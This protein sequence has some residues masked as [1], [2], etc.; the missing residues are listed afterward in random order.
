MKR[1]RGA[2]Q[3]LL[4]LGGLLPVAANA[5]MTWHWNATPSA[6]GD[7]ITASMDGCVSSWNSYATYNY[8]IGV[9][10]SS[11]TPT[12][13]AGYL[14]QIRFG[15]SRNYRTAMH[16]SCH[17]LGTG[18]GAGWDG[19]FRN[20]RWTGTY[21]Y[22]LRCAYAGPGE[23]MS[24]DSAHFWPY[25][26]NQDAEGVDAPR[27]VGIVGGFRRDMNLAQGDQT[28]GIASGTY[29]LRNRQTLGML[30]GS[31]TASSGTAA[32]QEV[33]GS[34]TTQQ[35]DV[36][37]VTGTTHFTI[38]NV[39]NGLYLDSAGGASGS[40]VVMTS[41]SGSPTNS[42]LWQ[43]NATDSFFFKIVNKATG[44]VLDNLDQAASGTGVYSMASGTA[45]GQ[46]WTFVHPLVQYAPAAGV[47]SQ[48]RPTTASTTESANYSWK[49][50]NGVPGDRWTASSG[51]FP[52]WWRTD[53]GSVQPITKV[54]VDWYGDGTRTYRYQIQTSNDDSTWTTVA[55]RSANTQA[56]AT[57]DS[58]SNVSARYVRVNVVGASAGYAAFYECRVSNQ[59]LPLQLVS[60]HRP[61][62]ASSQQSGN[63][64]VNANDVDSEYTRWT[65]STGTFPQ[66]WQVDL[67]SVM[68][69][70]KAVIEW[71]DR[72]NRSY[73]YRIEGSTDGTNY[74]TLV[75]RTGNT[76]TDTSVDSMSGVARYVRVVVTGSST[77][78]AAFYD[79][80]VYS[81]SPNLKT[82]LA[83][84]ESSGTTAADSSGGGNTGTL[85]NGPLWATGVT[86]NAVMLDG[87]NDH[88]TLPTGAVSTLGDCTISTWVFLETVGTWS[89]IFDFGSSTTVNMFLTPKSSTGK[90]RFAI[91]TSG[92]SG[93]QRIDGASALV[94]NQW[95]HVAVTLSGTTGTLY[96][97][98]AVAG[99]N[100][101]MTLYPALLGSTTKNYIGRSQYAD[102][103]L[104]GSVD[105]FRILDRA[106]SAEEVAAQM[107]RDLGN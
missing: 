96:V 62:T 15:G 61:T 90:P 21:A 105:N 74:T 48:G 67:G 102:P 59:V 84:N 35:W 23:R 7:Q 8:D 65:A 17:W 85:V 41:L 10:Y 40:A 104:D 101:A 2:R 13:D 97:N 106:L 71:Y 30:G 91:T 107:N 18:T 68:P 92:G 5:A 100:T 29:R 43:I 16:E 46:E 76:S 60:Q 36:S 34:A 31:A 57:E 58:L 3:L 4:I 93:E 28:I 80:Q 11:G 45:R 24:G 63:L 70:D 56:G 33:N 26:A 82:F 12:A 51:T 20:G 81:A 98:G 73:Q 39:Q 79:V 53:L 25:G 83:F 72:G 27:M 9:I 77:G 49:G 94:A 55:D 89:R 42:Q 47:I 50:N 75:D 38:R 64:A 87:V 44:L 99:T 69:V 86:G 54:A 19:F 103:Y 22:N 32:W 6:Y 88:V 1:C 78:Y 37:F 95:N 52:Q 14:G 66:W